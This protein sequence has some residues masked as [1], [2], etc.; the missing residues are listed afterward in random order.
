MRV[1]FD[2]THPANVHFFKHLIAMLQ[3]EQH[4]V[5]VVSRNKD[6][7]LSLLQDLNIPNLCLSEKRP[8]LI[9]AMKELVVRNLRLLRVA[10]QFRPDVLVAASAG[11]SIGPVGA[12]LGVPRLVFDQAD[13]AYLQLAL[14]LPFVTFICTGDGYLKDHGRRQIRFRSDSDHR[15]IVLHRFRGRRS[16]VIHRPQKHGQVC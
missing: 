4:H 10:R 14:G 2:I 16:V 3:Q 6:V 5:L 11:V 1:L 8:G 9:R 15:P 7:T 13:L 12:A